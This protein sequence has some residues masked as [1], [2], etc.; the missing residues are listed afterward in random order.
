MSEEQ[1][2]DMTMNKFLY[3]HFQSGNIMGIQTMEDHPAERSQ[4]HIVM[5]YNG[6]VFLLSPPYRPME[7]SICLGL[8]A[9][10]DAGRP[11]DYKNTMCGKGLD[12]TRWGSGSFH[13]MPAGTDG[14][15]TPGFC[16]AVLIRTR[17][18][19][20]RSTSTHTNTSDS[21]AIGIT[22]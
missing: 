19:C 4:W 20:I 10:K 16:Q 2:R 6:M 17:T 3:V 13:A 1:E 8:M 7:N 21:I 18:N 14:V 9:T 5:M 12:P 22:I 15:M 11:W